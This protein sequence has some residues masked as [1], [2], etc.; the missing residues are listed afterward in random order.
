MYCQ[1]L[2]VGCS[3]AGE[4]ARAQM[5]GT[6]GYRRGRADQRLDESNRQHSA[7]SRS[8]LDPYKENLRGRRGRVLQRFFE[9]P[10]HMLFGI[11][12]ESR[13]LRTARA[14]G[15]FPGGLAQEFDLRRVTPTPNA[16]KQV[17]PDAQASVPRKRGVH[18]L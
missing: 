17:N 7:K 13:A 11:I 14:G 6:V 3:A 1:H 10:P 12:G 9:A 2:V 16:I 5:R 4:T 18:R 8:R 15:E